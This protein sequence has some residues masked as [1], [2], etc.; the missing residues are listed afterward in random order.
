M[1]PTTIDRLERFKTS[2]D[3]I[4]RIP[5]EDFGEMLLDNFHIEVGGVARYFQ[6]V[7]IG[8]NI[9]MV[10]LLPVSWTAEPSGT[11]QLDAKTDWITKGKSLVISKAPCCRTDKPGK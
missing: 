4:I 5:G 2:P 10:K 8:Q 9:Y 1:T 11:L 3:T 7:P 6:G